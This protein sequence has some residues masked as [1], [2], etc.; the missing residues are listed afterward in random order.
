MRTTVQLTSVNDYPAWRA[1]ARRLLREGVRP[2][3]IEWRV[4]PEGDL[5]APPAPAGPSL[6]RAAGRVPLRFVRLAEAVLCHSDDSRFGLLYSLLWRLQ[7]DRALLGNLD[8]TDVARVNRR[9]E[10]VVTDFKRMRDG[11]RFRRAVAGDGHKGLA[12]HYS[13]EHF[14]LERVAPHFTRQVAHEDWVITTPY[15]TAYWNGKILSF[16]L[17]R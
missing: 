8:D 6:D 13:P 11:L 1:A 9:V 12:A 17:P 2:A 14:V 15:R 3:A 10:A 4:V 7:K 5:L 16:G